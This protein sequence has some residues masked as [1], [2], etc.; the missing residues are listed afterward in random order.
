MLIEKQIVGDEN[1]CLIIDE[2]DS[3]LFEDRSDTLSLKSLVENFRHIIG[4]SG[5]ELQEF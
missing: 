3:V 5:S 1:Y 4:F 2:F